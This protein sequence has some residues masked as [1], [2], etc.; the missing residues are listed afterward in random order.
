MKQY[1]VYVIELA[2]SVAD[3]RKFRKKTPIIL[4]IMPVFML[5]SLQENPPLDLNSIKRV[6]NQINM[7]NTMELNCVQISM[8]N[9]ILYQPEKMLKKLRRCLVIP[10][11]NK[12]MEFGL[13]KA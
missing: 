7:Q 6:I 3:I 13:I 10:Y 11:E 2:Q 4:K 1:F 9:I 8:K 5:A 12:D